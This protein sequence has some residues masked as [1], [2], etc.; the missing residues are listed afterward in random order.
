LSGLRIARYPRLQAGARVGVVAPAGTVDPARLDAGV[1]RLA[2]LGFD[3]VVG[4][5]VL[6]RRAYFAGPDDDRLADLA[7]MLAD[8]SVRAVFYARGGYGSQRLVPRLDLAA[9]ARA[10]KP[11]IGYSDATALLQA[12]VGAGVVAVHGPMVAVD[13]ARGLDAPCATHVLRLLGDPDYLWS[14]DVPVAIRP[15]RA[16][17]RL[18]G[19]CLS[20]LVTTLGTPWA[21]DTRGAVLFLEDTHEYPYRLDRLLTQCRQAG[22][23]DGVAGV[24][25]GTMETCRALNDVCALDVVRECFADAPFPVAFGL[26]SGHCTAGADVVNFALPLGV[27]VALDAAAGRLSALEPAAS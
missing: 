1:A 22:L 24:V 19:G 12:V 27:P 13:F 16:T 6:A 15:G 10:P 3:V 7:A 4:P 8:D 21:L 2:A 9:L 17:G 23:F 20:V 25:V 5:H 26:P 14:V 11:V 18:V